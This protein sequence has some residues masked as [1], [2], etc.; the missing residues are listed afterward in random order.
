MFYNL[1]RLYFILV[2]ILNLFLSH[3]ARI[4][5]SKQLQNISII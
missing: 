3:N 2:S 4:A 1:A 5:P